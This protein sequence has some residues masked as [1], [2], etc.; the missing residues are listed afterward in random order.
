M[1]AL[2][3]FI[4]G[5]A[6]GGAGGFL[7]AGGMGASSHDHAGHSD[8]GHDHSN[9]TPWNGP[10]PQLSMLLARDGD[11]LDLTLMIP[12]FTFTPLEVNK[13]PVQGTGHAHVYIDGVKVARAYSPYM[14]LEHVP[15]GAIVRVSFHAND[16]SLWTVDGKPIAIQ[17]TA[18]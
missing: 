1:R 3:L 17:A 8:S 9:A 7:A 2:L 15:S 13:Q 6:F 10:E 4:I 11:A 14:H 5:L 12:E 18:Q 16:H